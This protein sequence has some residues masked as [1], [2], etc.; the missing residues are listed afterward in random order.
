VTA[1]R[2]TDHAPYWLSSTNRLHRVKH[3]LVVWRGAN[4]HPSRPRLHVE[5][6]CRQ[7]PVSRPSAHRLTHSADRGSPC[8][9]CFGYAGSP[10][11]LRAERRAR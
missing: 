1:T 4:A 5:L 11:S 3:V 9:H 10:V 8:I 7:L 2:S 6:E